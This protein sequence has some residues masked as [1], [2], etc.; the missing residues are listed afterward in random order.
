MV[1]EPA[2][3]R[4]LL[5]PDYRYML[6]TAPVRLFKQPHP[7]HLPSQL[8]AQVGLPPE[9]AQ[10]AIVSNLDLKIDAQGTRD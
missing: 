6:R 7:L 4:F 8:G 1:V 9:G 5:D 10:G 2:S 3:A